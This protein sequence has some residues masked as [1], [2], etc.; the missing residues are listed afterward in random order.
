MSICNIPVVY[1]YAMCS[2]NKVS[3]G[4]V[5]FTS[6]LQRLTVTS[7]FNLPKSGEDL[8]GKGKDERAYMWSTLILFIFHLMF[9][10]LQIILYKQE[11]T[12]WKHQSG[13]EASNKGKQELL[14]KIRENTL[15]I[16]GIN[17]GDDPKKIKTFMK[18][19]MDELIGS[20]EII[21]KHAN[22]EED[23]QTLRNLAS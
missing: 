9:E 2:Y 12:A 22:D 4:S 23:V 17:Q 10:H 11:V 3:Q 19:T 18:K 21:R 14:K 6:Y 8:N 16:T 20:D 5:L 15:V 13:M 1:I 7:L